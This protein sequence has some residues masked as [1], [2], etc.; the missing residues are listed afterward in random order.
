M[1]SDDFCMLTALRSEDARV[2][3]LAIAY[4][5]VGAAERG[6]E[7]RGAIV[8]AVMGGREGEQWQ[9]CAGFATQCY[10]DALRFLR[11]AD[12]FWGCDN[13]FSSSALY[14]WASMHDKLTDWPRNGDLFLLRGGSTGHQHTGMVAKAER[15][16]FITIEGNLQDAVRMGERQRD[17]CDFVRVV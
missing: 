16:T 7:N 3:A 5:A 1:R 4:D 17:V 11:K 2:I 9:W 14:R 8:R 13:R 15:P 12:P 10:I 6:G